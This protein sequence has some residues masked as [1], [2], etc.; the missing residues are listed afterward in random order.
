MREEMVEGW[1]KFHDEELQN[2]YPSSNI[3]KII[4]SRRMK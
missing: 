1:R 4:E 3:I 2:L